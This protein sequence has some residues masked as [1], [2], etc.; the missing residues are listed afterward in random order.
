MAEDGGWNDECRQQNKW[1]VED[2][3]G[4]LVKRNLLKAERRRKHCPRERVQ[5]A[6]QAEAVPNQ[7]APPGNMTSGKCPPNDGSSKAY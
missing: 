6:E 1:K 7:Q 5:D 2:C 3:D 4:R